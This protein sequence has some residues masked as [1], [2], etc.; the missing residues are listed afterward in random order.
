MTIK[1][2]FWVLNGVLFIFFIAFGLISIRLS[3][4]QKEQYLEL[5][6]GS[7]V[8]LAAIFVVSLI[9]INQKINVPLRRLQEGIHEVDTDLL[10]LTH[11]ATG[12]AHCYLSQTIQI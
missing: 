5:I 4:N 2:F 11:V 3:L 7:L 1:K 12:L 10:Q 8:I 6:I 9:T